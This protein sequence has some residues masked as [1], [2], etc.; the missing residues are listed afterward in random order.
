MVLRA[1]DMKEGVVPSG[2][3]APCGPGPQGVLVKLVQAGDALWR[4]DSL[5]RQAVCGVVA[6]GHAL[7]DAQLPGAGWPRGGLCDILQEPGCH[8]EWQ[9]LLPALV[10]AQASVLTSGTPEAVGADPAWVA[11]IGAPYTPFGPGLAARGLDVTRLLW[12]Q[13]QTPA[14]RLW[15][16][17][18]A[19]R[20]SDVAA[21]LTW[22]GLVPTAALRRL[23]LAAHTHAK[24]LFAL[25][26]ANARHSAS[27]A[28]LRLLLLPDPTPEQRHSASAV[29]AGSAAVNLATDVPVQAAGNGLA[30]VLR[31]E[32]LK[33]RG[34]PLDHALELPLRKPAHALDRVAA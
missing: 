28:L 23:H 3:A 4:A 2:A 20:C 15:A 5:A 22:L 8:R 12:V 13:A 34:P 17:E 6:S 29:S 25:R 24:L 27:P 18:Q 9:L 7:L 10:A 30:P 16:A 14:E 32:L 31:V 19:L 11:L 33:R 1:V 21:V 26:P